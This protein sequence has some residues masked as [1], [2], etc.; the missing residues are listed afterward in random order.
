MDA[1]FKNKGD[2]LGLFIEECG[3]ALAAAGKTI[4]YGWDSVNPDLGPDAETNEMWLIREIADVEF[5][6][7]RLRKS[8][9]WE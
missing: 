1:R 5:A 8:R 6:I 4:R 7:A 9:G 3:E 2:S